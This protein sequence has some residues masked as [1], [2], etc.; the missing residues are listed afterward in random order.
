M[1]KE[2]T[3]PFF[4]PAV[5]FTFTLASS[6]LN[7]ALEKTVVGSLTWLVILPE[8]VFLLSLLRVL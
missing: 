7:I 2:P 1:K 5:L 4:V 8:P 6:S 3:A